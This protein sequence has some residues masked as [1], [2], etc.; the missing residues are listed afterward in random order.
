MVGFGDYDRDRFNL[1]ITAQ[2]SNQQALFAKDRS[3][4]KTGNVPPYITAAATGQGNIEGG[5]IPGTGLRC[6]WH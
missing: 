5:Y 2:Y 4:A 1:T 6:E 3:F